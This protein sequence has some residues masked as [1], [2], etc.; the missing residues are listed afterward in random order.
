MKVL[1]LFYTM[2]GNT[3]K[4]AGQIG[5]TVAS[6]GHAVDS[7][8]IRKDTEVDLLAYDFLF[9]GSGVY[10]WLPGKPLMELFTK[11]R[12]EY[13]DQEVIKP[14][15]PLQPGKH[16]VVYCTYGGCHT[17]IQEAVPTN[18]YLRQLFEH[19]GFGI[20]A[21]W[22]LVGEY[23]GKLAK[24]STS[25]RLGDITGRPNAEDLRQLAENVRGVLRAYDHSGEPRP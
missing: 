12:R 1:N 6:L 14:G 21:E 11:L 20:A 10:E 24:L 5:A 2:T 4:V 7:V 19:L 17:G 3:E 22:F 16:A 25:G 23:H 9:I 18:Q 8:K 13:A 15:A